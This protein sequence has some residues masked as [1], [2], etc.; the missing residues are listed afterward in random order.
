MNTLAPV[1]YQSK[2][3]LTTQ[4]VADGYEAEPIKIQQNFSNNKGRY[5]QGI[6]YF[7]LEGEELKAFKSDLENFEVAPNVNKMFLWTEKGCLLHAKSLNTDRA[8]E[9]YQELVDTYFRANQ[10]MDLSQLSPDI[11]LLNQMIT[12]MA[13]QELAAKEAKRL[14][15]EAKANAEQAKEFVAEIKDTMAELPKD[16]WRGWVNTSLSE[17][18]IKAGNSREN[19]ETIRSDSYFLLEERAAADLSARIRNGRKRLSEAGATK[20]TIEK[21]RK[22]DAIE[23]DK[24]LKEIYTGIIRELRIKYLV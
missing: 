22:L 23:E 10:S 6:H 18:A 17:I 4:Q 13:K 19:H 21:Y 14:A 16:Q 9:V 24:R 12:T 20:T 7:I 15:I 2:R 11:Q 8:W 1:E 3:V 5:F